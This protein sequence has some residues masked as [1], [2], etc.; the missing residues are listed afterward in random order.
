MN[1]LKNLINKLYRIVKSKSSI[2]K[3]IKVNT[4]NI[5]IVTNIFIDF[6]SPWVEKI[7]R[8]M[9]DTDEVMINEVRSGETVP[10]KRSVRRGTSKAS[11]KQNSQNITN[12]ELNE[13]CDLPRRQSILEMRNKNQNE[14]NEWHKLQPRKQKRKEAMVHLLEQDSNHI[15][16]KNHT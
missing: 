3:E 11:R 15:M 16:I 10:M 8:T 13:I 9:K 14:V 5:A 12:S 6:D 4:G 7:D 1:C 2:H